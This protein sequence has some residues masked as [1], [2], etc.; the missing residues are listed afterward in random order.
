MAK[1]LPTRPMPSAP[2]T[3]TVQ[4]VLASV[5]LLVG[6]G[7]TAG[8]AH[9]QTRLEQ[10]RAKHEFLQTADKLFTAT[11]REIQTFMEVLDSIRQLHALSEQVT[12]DAFEEVVRKG[13]LYQRRVL[14]AYGFAQRIPAALRAHYE[15]AEGSAHPIVRSDGRGGFTPTPAT[16]DYFPLTYQTP[17]GGLGVV[18]GYD[19]GSHADDRH[20]IAAMAR[21][22]VFALGSEPLGAAPDG[23]R[24]QRYMFAPIQYD[25]EGQHELIG[26]AIALFQPERLLAAAR[27]DAM[28]DV[29]A[30]L[31]P[32]PTAAAVPAP[33]PKDSPLESVRA[34]SLADQE[35]RLVVSADPSWRRAARLQTP[36]IIIGIGSAL[37]LGLAA[38]LFLMAS[39]SRRVEALVQ[40]RTAELA[41]ANQQL[42][43]LMEDRREL[44]DEVLQIAGREKARLGRD[45][46][47][48]LGQKLTG[49]L[50]LFSAFRR[51]ATETDPAAETEASQISATLKEAVR[52]VRR[53]ARGLAPI[54]LTEDGLG[55]ALRHLAE[56]S[57]ALFQKDV[58]FYIEREGRPRDPVTAEHV[59]L[60][61]QE[62]IHNAAKH[63]NASR[64][65]ITLDYDDQGGLLTIEDNGAGWPEQPVSKD[66][67]SGLRIMRHR[68]E[69]FGGRLQL[70]RAPNGGASV[71]CRF[72]V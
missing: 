11:L 16:T 54:A 13:M 65:V 45:L 59:Y 68:A 12:P 22:G 9:W 40:K 5:V 31:E 36:L 71:I 4:I 47:D 60:I 27:G 34:F 32:R 7:L 67:G 17:P 10:Q 29:H 48:S 70:A 23:G 26:F 43:A 24:N 30:R 15:S 28:R 1:E 49:A 6:L 50:Y 37:S 3:A 61:A 38:A 52:Q 35:W 56:E 42:E 20:A 39:R 72:P 62:A 53:I 8:I 66:V 58:E 33:A 14:G 69:L 46:H 63:A 57:R 21:L 25:L 41:Q 64:I 19:F 2:R 51:R 44:E 18:L 55:D